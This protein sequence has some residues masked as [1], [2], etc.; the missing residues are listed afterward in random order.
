MPGSLSRYVKGSKRVKEGGGC[1]RKLLKCEKDTE[2][3][4]CGG[5][6]WGGMA[7][8]TTI[9]PLSYPSMVHNASLLESRAPSGESCVKSRSAAEEKQIADLSSTGPQCV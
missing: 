2:G 8:R 6:C 3:C 1:G 4:V 7:F 9:R 5:V